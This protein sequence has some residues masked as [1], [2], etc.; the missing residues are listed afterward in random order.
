M[1]RLY[2]LR[3]TEPSKIECQLVHAQDA[4]M[5]RS[6]ENMSGRTHAQGWGW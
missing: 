6:R 5:E 3:A 1:C 4:L 2:G